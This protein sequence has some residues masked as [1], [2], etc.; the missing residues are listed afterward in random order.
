MLP[1]ELWMVVFQWVENTADLLRCAWVCRLWRHCIRSIPVTIRADGKLSPKRFDDLEII[2]K[3]FCTINYLCLNLSHAQQDPWF[4]VKP[5][6]HLGRFLNVKALALTNDLRGV[7]S[8]AV[9]TMVNTR[10]LTEIAFQNVTIG[11]AMVAQLAAGKLRLERLLLVYTRGDYASDLIRAVRST[12]SLT[13]VPTTTHMLDAAVGVKGLETLHFTI[14]RESL[15][16]LVRHPTA[17]Q[18]ETLRDLNATSMWHD[19]SDVPLSAIFPFDIGHIGTFTL[20]VKLRITHL[21]VRSLSPSRDLQTLLDIKTLVH[22]W[23]SPRAYAHS[24]F[25]DVKASPSLETLVLSTD[26][27]AEVNQA[28]G[29]VVPKVNALVNTNEQLTLTLLYFWRYFTLRDL[30]A[31]LYDDPMTALPFSAPARKAVERGAFVSATQTW[32]NTL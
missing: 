29:A 32:W 15:G 11:R 21:V 17:L 20:L 27:L 23:Y 18:R 10:H 22:L 9:L 16:G 28:Y 25:S 4:G 31:S 7:H 3:L 6:H 12:S 24:L 5:G 2:G 8:S 30:A 1:E 19:M 14:S 26:D 13:L